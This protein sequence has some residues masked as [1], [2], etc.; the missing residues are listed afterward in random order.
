[1]A[2]KIE[3]RSFGGEY[4]A[5]ARMLAPSWERE[6]T[7]YLHFSKQQLRYLVQS[8]QVDRRWTLGCYRGKELLGFLLTLGKKVRMKSGRKVRVALNTLMTVKKGRERLLPHLHMLEYIA[9]HRGNAGYKF[10]LGFVD[11]KISNN[12]ILGAY[13]SH[14]YRYFKIIR[15]FPYFVRRLDLDDLASE[16]VL[17]EFFVSATVAKKERAA[18]LRLVNAIKAKDF[19]E[20][21]SARHFY[22][23]LSGKHHFTFVAKKRRKVAGI[24]HGY[25]ANMVSG[26]R[27]VKTAVVTTVSVDALNDAEKKAAIAE[28]MNGLRRRGVR[29]V[30]RGYMGIVSDSIWQESGFSRSFSSLNAYVCSDRR[31]PFRRP[32]KFAIEII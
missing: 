1:M 12:S 9:A 28:M 26:P 20:A 31:W 15:T 17:P 18:C 30:I 16:P 25:I 7:S 24:F 27:A 2:A 6:H 10:S 13:L 14:R 29:Q 3:V 22:P 19:S 5:L 32:C 8:P 21:W 4:G 23:R 11:S